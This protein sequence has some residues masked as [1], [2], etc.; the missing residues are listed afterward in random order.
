MFDLLRRAWCSARCFF[1]LHAAP[2]GLIDWHAPYTPG[3]DVLR[4]RI[5]IGCPRCKKEIE[6]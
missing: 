3:D 2:I 5:Y 6:K 4:H 1:G